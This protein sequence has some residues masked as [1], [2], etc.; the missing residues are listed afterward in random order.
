[1]VQL[2]HGTLP[3]GSRNLSA[4]NGGV[5]VHFLGRSGDGEEGWTGETG[6]PDIIN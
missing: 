5:H 1:M 3:R 2:R 4:L 6:K